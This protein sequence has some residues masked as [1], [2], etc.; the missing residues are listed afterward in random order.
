MS[1]SH[2]KLSINGKLESIEKEFEFTREEEKSFL[3][4]IQKVEKYF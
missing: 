2:E 1:F 4:N 3:P